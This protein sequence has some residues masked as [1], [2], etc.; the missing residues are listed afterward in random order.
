MI[1]P[2]RTSRFRLGVFY[3]CGT[4]NLYNTTKLGFLLLIRQRLTKICVD[5]F[6]KLWYKEIGKSRECGE[7]SESGGQMSF[8]SISATT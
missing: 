7:G 4:G 3:N 1:F 6:D 2:I 5:I 8:S